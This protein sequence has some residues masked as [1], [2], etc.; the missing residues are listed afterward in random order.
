LHPSVIKAVL[1]GNGTVVP[2]Q[3]VTFSLSSEIGQISPVSGTARTN[4][5]GEAAIRLTADIIEGTG[6]LTSRYQGVEQ[7]ISSCSKDDEVISQYHLTLEMRN[8]SGNIIQKC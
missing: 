4:A 7:T 2:N 8:G 1:T 6:T 5:Q 3:L